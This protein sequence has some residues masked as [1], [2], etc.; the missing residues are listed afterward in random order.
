MIFGYTPRSVLHSAIFREDS[1]YRRW[2]QMQ[3]PN[4]RP[5]AK[6]RDLKDT[7][8]QIFSLIAQAIT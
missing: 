4:V 8:H 6:S 3:R 2:E 1:F 5:Y 7:P